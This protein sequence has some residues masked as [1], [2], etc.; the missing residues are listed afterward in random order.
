LGASAF[1]A[2][3]QTAQ[4]SSGIPFSHGFDVTINGNA[5]IHFGLDT[6]LAWDFILTSEQAK[7]FGLP[8]VD[9][10]TMY[11]SDKQ[12]ALGAKSDIVQAKTLTLAGY[13]FSDLKGLAVPNSHRGDVGITLFRNVLLTLDYPHD[14]LR[15]SDGQLP[16]AN[17]HDILAY[18]TDPAANFKV[19]QVSPMVS[20]QLAGQPLQALIDTGAHEVFGEIIVPRDVAAKLPLGPQV[21]TMTL[22]DAL[23][24]K[25]P[26]YVAPLKGDLQLGD[27]LVHNPM[28]TVS[29]WLGFVNVGPLTKR[30]VLTIDQ[31][32][33]RVRVVMPVPAPQTQATL[34]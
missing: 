31:V 17:G 28:V 6:G 15:V 12:T 4:T 23:G 1:I 5:P 26:S 24:R 32:N 13:T 7:L 34:N 30:L 18:T 2:F 14:L 27:V 9:Q 29:D 19:L 20:I 3:G 22:A 33:H 21:G 11:T 25:F 8:V 10:H 16:P